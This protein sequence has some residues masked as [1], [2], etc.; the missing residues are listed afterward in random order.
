MVANAHKS[1]YIGPMMRTVDRSKIDDWI[2]KNGPNGL[3]KLSIE[4]GIPLSSLAKIRSGWVPVKKWT[5]I[6]LA[7]K[8]GVTEDELFPE[9]HAHAL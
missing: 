2:A 8:L 3:A 6:A 4:S 9:A 5:R 1:A 7:E